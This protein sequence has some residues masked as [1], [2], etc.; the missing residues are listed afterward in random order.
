MSWRFEAKRDWCLE[1]PEA[2]RTL[3]EYLGCINDNWEEWC[4]KSEGQ[5]G[6]QEEPPW[7]RGVA[8]ERHDLV[9]GISRGKDVLGWEYSAKDAEDM[10]AEFARRAVPFLKQHQHFREGEYLHLMQHYR[11][12]T[13]LLD[14]TKGALIALY[15]AITRK[16]R[17][18]E[19]QTT[20][21]KSRGPC[22]WMLNPSWLNNENDV[23]NE[24]ASVHPETEKYKSLLR[25]TDCWA[26]EKYPE[27]NIVGSSG[28]YC[29]SGK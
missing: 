23:I 29:V 6:R 28:I 4:K 1:S 10:K 3:A 15:F 7:F 16:S 13:R 25:Y 17:E 22:V 18:Q 20:L 5:W 26:M 14:W 11:F 19:E 9:P 24:V 27:D 12:P 2:I 8:N 21:E